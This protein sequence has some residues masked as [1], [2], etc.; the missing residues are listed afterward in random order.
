MS[1]MGPDI[2]PA[3]PHLY[4]VKKIKWKHF[5]SLFSDFPPVRIFNKYEVTNLF[6]Y[7]QTPNRLLD[8]VVKMLLSV[9]FGYLWK[10]FG[11]TTSLKVKSPLIHWSTY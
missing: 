11:V 8:F 9:E 1:K 2:Q 3:R 4:H 6:A 10:Y 7:F 5:P